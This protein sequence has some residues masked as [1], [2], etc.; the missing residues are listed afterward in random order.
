MKTS[1]LHNFSEDPDLSAPPSPSCFPLRDGSDELVLRM[2]VMFSEENL[3]GNRVT[4]P[5]LGKESSFPGVSNIKTQIFLH[6]S[7][8]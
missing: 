5:L 6:I 3:E 4:L 2:L 7:L 8:L 1:Q